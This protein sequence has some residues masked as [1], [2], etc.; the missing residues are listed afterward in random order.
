MESIGK[1][2]VEK[3]VTIFSYMTNRNFLEIFVFHKPH[4]SEEYEAFY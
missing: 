2:E 1:N 3:V 4:D